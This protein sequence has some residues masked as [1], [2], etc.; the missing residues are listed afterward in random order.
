MKITDLTKHYI[1]STTD[2]SDVTFLK[3]LD[4]R[5]SPS[6]FNPKLGK[7]QV[8]LTLNYFLP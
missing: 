8:S 6:I 1:T 5:K 7:V 3:S 2:D 4:D